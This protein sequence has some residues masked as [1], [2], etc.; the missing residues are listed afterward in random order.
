MAENNLRLE[1]A[2]GMNVEV[3]LGN[4]PTEQ[5]IVWLGQV[6]TELASRGE[7]EAALR[8]VQDI[9][10]PPQELPQT[11]PA[12]TTPVPPAPEPPQPEPIEVKRPEP[13]RSEDAAAQ[14][15]MTETGEKSGLGAEQLTRARQG[16]IDTLS[17]IN[18]RRKVHNV[19]PVPVMPAEAFAAAYTDWVSRN[20]SVIEG[21]GAERPALLIARPAGLVF[22]DFEGNIGLLG[23]G[24]ASQATTNHLYGS[25]LKYKGMQPVAPGDSGAGDTGAVVFGLMTTQ[26]YQLMTGHAG[27]HQAFAQTQVERRPGFGM[28]IPNVA[29]VYVYAHT[30]AAGPRPD[31][32]YEGPFLHADLGAAGRE[33][34]R[35]PDFF[36]VS[37]I[38]WQGTEES[39][40]PVVRLG[41]APDQRVPGV[42]VA[43]GRQ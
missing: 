34:R 29:D 8:T 12:E 41:F 19:P 1:L 23:T 2:P 18:E 25:W 4:V 14:Q 9:T 30:I 15:L 32:C 10:H 6:G 43:S 40:R 13:R 7:G 37:R 17:A 21:F 22:A 28:H 33:D 3:K 26:P 42:L 36:L 16:Y 20:G 27:V 11:P 5:L 39:Q 31:K 24:A 35:G 38:F